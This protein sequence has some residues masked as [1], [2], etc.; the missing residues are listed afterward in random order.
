MFIPVLLTPVISCS[1]MSVTPAIN[2]C[3]GFSVIAGVFDNGDKFI[4]SD[5]DT[6][7]QFSPVTTTPAI[8]LLPVIMTLVNRVLGEFMGRVFSWRF[9]MKQ[10]A[11]VYEA[12]LPP[13]TERPRPLFFSMTSLLSSPSSSPSARGTL[14]PPSS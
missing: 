6:G 5:N 9:E 2:H 4:A 14:W 13:F 11:A 8:N 7:E 3:H 10:S 1:P 12:G